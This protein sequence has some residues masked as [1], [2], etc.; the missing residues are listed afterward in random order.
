MP[1]NKK[2]TII[3]SIREYVRMYPDINNWKINI[4][5]LGNGMEY[6]IDPIGADPIYKRYVDG[7]CLKQFQFAL[8]SKEAYDGDA[9]TGIANSG[10]YQNFDEPCYI[11]VEAVPITDYSAQIELSQDS[12][13]N[14]TMDDKQNGVNHLVVTGK[15]EMQERNIFH[16]YVQKDGSIGK[17]QYYKGLNEIS[18]VYENTSTETAELEKTSVEQ[19]QKLMNKK[20][21]QMDVAKLG[22]EVGIGDIVGGRDYLTGMYMSKPIENIIYEITND[23]ESIT[24]KLEGEDEE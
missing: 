24:Y 19:L 3:E 4:D 22:I 14:F 18:A 23:V 17:T 10:F 16:L 7:S 9:R 21:F 2:K 5:R 6:S 12:R 11:L 8:T 20:T 15:G 13:L 1:E